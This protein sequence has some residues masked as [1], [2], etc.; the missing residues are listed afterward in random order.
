M[1]TTERV[2]LNIF[3]LDDDAIAMITQ[4]DEQLRSVN[5]QVSGMLAYFIK[6]AKLE[7]TW[8]IADNRRE[9]V[10]TDDKGRPLVPET[11][12]TNGS[13]TQ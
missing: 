8:K 6:K 10:R 3:P 5:A 1:A 9:L 2:S 13:V 12:H 4:A 11:D 7:G